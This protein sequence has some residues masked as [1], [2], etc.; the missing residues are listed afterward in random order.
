MKKI[1]K[2]FLSEQEMPTQWYN[3]QADMPHKMMP[4]LNP[5]T[6][7]PLG[8]ADYVITGQAPLSASC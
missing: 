1:R 6:K 4:P 8:P 3:I 2:I 7:E 5:V